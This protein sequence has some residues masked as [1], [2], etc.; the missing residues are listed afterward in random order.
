MSRS[1]CHIERTTWL[2]PCSPRWF[3]RQIVWPHEYG[4]VALTL[5][6]LM[7]RDWR[8]MSALRWL[9]IVRIP[10]RAKQCFM[11]WAGGPRQTWYLP[12]TG[13]IFVWRGLVVGRSGTWRTARHLQCCGVDYLVG[14]RVRGWGSAI[15]AWTY[16]G[17][18]DQ[19]KIGYLKK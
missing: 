17:T 1:A 18:I 6:R 19:S 14:L 7:L 3:A 4:E 5:K 2:Y 8:D 16:F 9:Q 13:K 12:K 15:E 11:G 10:L